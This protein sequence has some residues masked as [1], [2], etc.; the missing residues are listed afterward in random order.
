MKTWI[1][2]SLA[3]TLIAAS[4]LASSNAV[5]APWGD[6]DGGPHGGMHGMRH[7]R[8]D[9]AAIS[10]R[11]TERLAGLQ[12]ALALKPDQLAEWERFKG[13]MQQQAR[14]AAEHMQAVRM[15]ERPDT[16]L[17]RMERMERFGSERMAAMQDV[18][19]ATE[20]LYGTLDAVQKKAFDEQF[21]LFGPEGMGPG[22]RRPG[23]KGPGMGPGQAG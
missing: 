4:G 12:V 11:A 21:R 6:C 17:G 8:M 1:T 7:G 16:A 23:R 3:V 2:T 14:K 15:Q 13:V 5:A 19:K 20:T 22:G 10:D 9:P 18:R